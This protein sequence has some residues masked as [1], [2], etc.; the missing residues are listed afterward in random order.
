MGIRTVSAVA[1]ALALA[2]TSLTTHAAEE[3]IVKCE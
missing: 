2:F 1:T 3:L